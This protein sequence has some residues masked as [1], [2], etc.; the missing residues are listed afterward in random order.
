MKSRP[1]LLKSNL[2]RRLIVAVDRSKGTQLIYA[3]GKQLRPLC[4]CLCL[5]DLTELIEIFRENL[6]ERLEAIRSSAASHDL[7][8]LTKAAHA[9]KSAIGTF[10]AQ[11]AHEAL[12]SLEQLARQGNA[13][14]CGDA[15]ST[16]LHEV[17][18]FEAELSK[19]DRESTPTANSLEPV[20]G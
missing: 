9:L 7:P 15:V 3:C 11:S 13:A 16:A 8:T 20:L 1:F 19:L 4:L 10:A 12:A 5:C 17:S 14:K 6:P 2:D 18:R